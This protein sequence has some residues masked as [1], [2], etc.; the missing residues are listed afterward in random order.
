MALESLLET[1]YGD[2]RIRLALIDSGFRPNKMEAGAESVVYDF[3]RS[4]MRNTRPSKGAASLANG[5]LAISKIEIN[6]GHGKAKYG[7]ELIRVNT[8]WCKLWVHERIRWPQDQPGAFFLPED[9]TDDYCAQLLSEARVKNKLGRAE[10]IRRSRENHYLDC[11]A[12]AYA[13]GYMLNVHHIG[14]RAEPA[15]TPRERDI[16]GNPQ[17]AKPT[18]VEIR[19]DRPAATPSTPKKAPKVIRSTF[20]MR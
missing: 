14:G 8:D 13:A 5:A 10:W 7:L 16:D 17:T 9:V 11:E 18:A 15:L 19:T 3:C 4:H 2:L 1:T 6:P 20:M 12:M